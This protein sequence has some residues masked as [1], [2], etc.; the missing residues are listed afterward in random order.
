MPYKS[1][2]TFVNTTV[3]RRNEQLL[4]PSD[5]IFQFIFVNFILIS[6]GNTPMLADLFIMWREKKKKKK[7]NFPVPHLIV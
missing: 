6:R 4:P 1:L 2:L 7:K 3:T 5:S